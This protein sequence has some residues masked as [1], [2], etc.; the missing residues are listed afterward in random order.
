[1]LAHRADRAVHQ[2]PR[3]RLAARARVDRDP[4]G[5]GRR[6]LDGR[7]ARE[8]EAARPTRRARAFGGVAGAFLGSYLEHSQRAS[9]FEF[10]FSIFILAMIILGGLGSIW[11]VVLGALALTYI[12]YYLIPGR[13]PDAAA[14]VRAELRAHRPVVRDL[15]LPARDHDAAAA[16]GPAAGAP[17]EDRARPRASA[18][19]RPGLRGAGMSADGPG[20]RRRSSSPQQRLEDLRRPRRGQRRRRSPC[21][22]KSIVSI[23]GPNG[24]GKTTFFNMLT[25]LYK[26]TTGRIA[27]DGT[28]IT[29]SAAG[30]ASRSAGVART[31]QNIRLFG[32]MSALE[33][34]LVGQ[35]ARMRGRPVRLD[36]AHP[37]RAARGA[38]RS[39]RR[40]ARCSS[41]SACARARSTTSSRSTSPTATSGAWRSPARWPRSPSCSCSTSP[42]RG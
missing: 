33:N 34:V 8:D 3:A 20:P 39:A 37:E 40:P 4:R 21:P 24:A 30:P 41:S 11:G 14:H 35:H 25:G 2:H 5:R 10:S 28:D 18:P 29:R 9:Q 17:A 13:V 26:P 12:N 7:A 16:R 6:G 31:F 42:R 23:I 38:A 22:A 19:T 1:M 36:R 32:T 27:F 15:R